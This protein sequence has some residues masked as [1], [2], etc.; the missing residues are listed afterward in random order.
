MTRSKSRKSLASWRYTTVKR[1]IHKVQ[2]FRRKAKTIA[3]IDAWD[4]VEKWMWTILENRYQKNGAN[5]LPKNISENDGL[6]YR[7]PE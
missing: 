2:K 1:W 7:L 6:E 4:K 5:R 3:E